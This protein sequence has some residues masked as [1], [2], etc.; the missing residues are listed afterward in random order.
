MNRVFALRSG[1]SVT[2]NING[3]YNQL[4]LDTEEEAIDLFKRALNVKNNPTDENVA[5]LKDFIDPTYRSLESGILE[6]DRLGNFYLKGY[7]MP[8]P[9]TL[10]RKIKEYFEQE[11]PLTAL[12]NFWKLCMLN[13]DEH[14]RQNLFDFAEQFHFPI[15]DSGYFI[16]YKSVAGINMKNKRYALF[17][18]REYLSMKAA[19]HNNPKDYTI[20][21]TGDG[22][23]AVYSTVKT[24][25]IDT[26]LKNNLVFCN[27]N[28]IEDPDDPDYDPEL[29][30]EADN[31]YSEF[32]QAVDWLME[33]HKLDFVKVQGYMSEEETVT[34][35]KK[36]GFEATEPLEL[37]KK[38]RNYQELGTLDELFNNLNVLMEQE[39]QMFTDWHSKKF[40]IKLGTVVSMPRGECD[41]NPNN[42]CSSGLHVGAPQYVTDFYRHDDQFILAVLVNPMNVVAVPKDYSYQK[43]RTCEYYP[44]AICEIGDNGF[45]KELETPYFET[46][47]CGYEK[48]QLEAQ[49][50]E[51][52]KTLNEKVD[53]SAE[54]EAKLQDETDLLVNRLFL[55]GGATP[56]VTLP[57]PDGQEPNQF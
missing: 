17:I 27:E 52:Q 13:P 55:I 57:E 12:E 3:A 40:A 45:L 48:E 31:P 41:N 54:D 16:A 50:Q 25:E 4:V 6:K 2:L 49:L 5:A 8:M 35:A 29:G 9:M 47:Y 19:M 46:D 51:V 32:E 21:S 10:V 33:N 37:W 18:A 20:V 28:C 11:F 36:L 1:T 34:Y 26:W 42:T 38:D 56:A 22:Q 23:D 53:L 43:M 39:E 30:V 24:S 14:A 44:Y 7:K 15:T